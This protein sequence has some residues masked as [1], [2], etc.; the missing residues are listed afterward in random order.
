[1]AS[2]CRQ[3]CA[4]GACTPLPSW[5]TIG[6]RFHKPARKGSAE[7][8]QRQEI[9]A[10]RLRPVTVLP[11]HEAVADRRP[12]ARFREDHLASRHRLADDLAYTAACL[13]QIKLPAEFHGR[14]CTYFATS[15]AADLTKPDL[16]GDEI[17][18]R[19]G[20]MLDRPIDYRRGQAL[21]GGVEGL[22]H[23]TLQPNQSIYTAAPRV[24]GRAARPDA[25]TARH[26]RRRARAGRRAAD[27]DAAAVSSASGSRRSARCAR[28][29]VSGCCGR[30]AWMLRSSAWPSLAGPAARFGASLLQAIFAY[31]RDVGRRSCRHRGASR[32]ADHGGGALS[33]GQRDRWLWAGGPDR[34]VP[35]AGACRATTKAALSCQ[36]VA[37]RGSHGR[38]P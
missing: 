20:F 4:T 34:L 27:R 35:G 6:G 10:G 9:E 11:T 30:P 31:V 8:W 25:R 17:R 32:C 1:M 29:R 7:L 28:P 33:F 24:P 26:A 37:C 15:S 18:M 13:R 3:A 19:L 22:D 23:C 14:R 5:P 12:V 36:G 16:G 38:A 2:W 21:A